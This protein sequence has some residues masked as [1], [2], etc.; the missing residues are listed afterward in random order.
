MSKQVR[1]RVPAAP[2]VGK[3]AGAVL[4]GVVAAASG[5]EPRRLLLVGVAA[6]ALAAWGLR[7]VLAPVRLA[8]DADGVTVVTGYA[9]RRRI[10]WADIERVRVGEHR[11]LG[12]RTQILEIDTG[13]TLHLFS[14]HDLGAP[15]DDV[16][17][18]LTALR[19]SAGG[20]TAEDDGEE[21]L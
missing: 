12:R 13:E 3:L 19:P 17:Q 10:P 1:W 14:R 15:C 6:L 11:S 21:H 8:A 18:A 2:A 7:D 9:R 4:L 20:Q 5:A 16:E